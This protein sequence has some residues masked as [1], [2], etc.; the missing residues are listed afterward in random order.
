M[1]KTQAIYFTDY[2]KISD[3]LM[4]LDKDKT[5]TFNVSLAYKKSDG[6]RNHFHKEYIY[7]SKYL[8]K[9]NVIS[10]KRNFTYYLSITVKNDFNSSVMINQSNMI[11]LKNKLQI[12]YNWFSTLYQYKDDKLVETK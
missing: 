11:A 4:T 2:E 6:T 3:V 1:N 5:L 12:V 10:I 9:N 8:D 7:A